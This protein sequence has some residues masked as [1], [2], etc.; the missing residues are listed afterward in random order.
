MSARCG[1]VQV[2]DEVRGLFR[3]CLPPEHRIVAER[4]LPSLLAWEFLVEGPLMPVCEAGADP[5]RVLAIYT[6]DQGSIQ[7]V[8]LTGELWAGRGSLGAW[9]VG[10]WPTL[11]AYH[12]WRRSFER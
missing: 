12:E 9:S 2:A 4:E 11:L 3:A 7:G 1:V 6:L 5:V 10:K 8:S